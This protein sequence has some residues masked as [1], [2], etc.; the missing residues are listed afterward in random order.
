MI[1]RIFIALAT[2]NGQLSRKDN[3]R[4]ISIPLVGPQLGWIYFYSIK[5]RPIVI[6]V[7]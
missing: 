1:Q 5:C 2:L 4:S 7:I 3:S 6:M